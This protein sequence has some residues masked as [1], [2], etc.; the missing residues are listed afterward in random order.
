MERNEIKNEISKLKLDCSSLVEKN[1]IV[2]LYTQKIIEKL[3][4]ITTENNEEVAVKSFHELLSA[5]W[6]LI[7]GS[8]LSYTA[9]PKH[10]LT[11]FLCYLSKYLAVYYNDSEWPAIRFLMPTVCYESY[12]AKY[13]DLNEVDLHKV[14]ET[15]V[16]SHYRGPSSQDF[17]IPIALLTHHELIDFK[18]IK[19]I[20]NPYFDHQKHLESQASFSESELSR[21]Y[22]HSEL[23]KNIGDTIDEYFSS[24]FPSLLNK[25]QKLHTTLKDNS[26]IGSGKE[27]KA[28]ELAYAEIVEFMTFWDKLEENFIQSIPTIK[29]EIELIKDLASDKTKNNDILSCFDIRQRKLQE[30]IRGNEEKLIKITINEEID[31]KNHKK[32]EELILR[33]KQKITVLNRQL[34]EDTY[35]GCDAL[36]AITQNI[37]KEM[38][39]VPGLKDI[40][41]LINY[42]SKLSNEK[43]N[44]FCTIN[45]VEI[46][47]VIKV[48]DLHFLAKLP[49]ESFGPLLNTVDITKLI[50]T[51]EHLKSCLEWFSLTQREI[52]CEALGEGLSS[53]IKT[54]SGYEGVSQY[55]P[56]KQRAVIEC[57]FLLESF[58]TYYSSQELKTYDLSINI[59]LK[60]ELINVVHKLENNPTELEPIFKKLTADQLDFIFTDIKETLLSILRKGYALKSIFRYLNTWLSSALVDTLKEE[61]PVII[62]NCNCLKETLLFLDS[63]QQMMLLQSI[64][65]CWLLIIKSSADFKGVFECLKGTKSRA[66]VFDACIDIILSKIKNI[67]DFIEVFKNLNSEQRTTLLQNFIKEENWSLI[68]KNSGDFNSV[69][70]C[71]KEANSRAIM[72]DAYKEKLQYII[73]SGADLKNIF[74]YLTNE[75]REFIFNLVKE[76]LASKIENIFHFS[77]AFMYLT[78]EQCMMLLQN[79]GKECWKLIIKNSAAFKKALACF[80]EEN[81]RAVVFNTCI[82]IIPSKIENIFRF[83]D[84][85]MYLTSEQRMMLLQSFDKE[86]WKLVIKSSADFKKALACFTEDNQRAVIFDACIDIIPLKIENIFHFSD[87]FI[88]LTSEQRMMLLQNFDKE[89]WKLIIKSSADFKKVLE[90]LTKSNLCSIM[91]D[92][93]KEQLLSII[94]TADFK[95]FIDYLPVEEFSFVCKVLKEEQSQDTQVSYLAV[96]FNDLAEDRLQEVCKFF[97]NKLFSILSNINVSLINIFKDLTDARLRIIC[98]IFKDLHSILPIFDYLTKNQLN[99]VLGIFKE[100]FLSILKDDSNLISILMDQNSKTCS[101]VCEFFYDECRKLIKNSYNLLVCL[102]A[103]KYRIVYQTL[104]L[105]NLPNFNVEEGFM[106]NSQESVLN[107]HSSLADIEFDVSKA[108]LMH[109]L[110]PDHIAINANEDDDEYEGDE[111]ERDEYESDKYENDDEEDVQK[112]NNIDKENL[113]LLSKLGDPE[114]KDIVENNRIVLTNGENKKFKIEDLFCLFILPV[115]ELKKAFCVDGYSS[116][117]EILSYLSQRNLEACLHE[118]NLK[119]AFHSDKNQIKYFFSVLATYFDLKSPDNFLK[120]IIKYHNNLKSREEQTKSESFSFFNRPG[121]SKTKIDQ[122]EVEMFEKKTN[123]HFFYLR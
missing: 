40:H 120:K 75:Q 80:T 103:D 112:L 46:L 18:E 13:P 26:V 38:C 77:N 79:F 25:L 48:E 114:L 105:E 89:R 60:K 85:F 43:I 66:I 76:T 8:L 97:N 104:K 83:S 33:F 11:K 34:K 96:L 24:I 102:N 6:N 27:D 86:R 110:F 78:S 20:Y 82:D 108:P 117:K 14:L 64:K 73:H 54:R 15:H 84:A 121:P 95:I 74:E 116:Q 10:P 47:G 53:I 3:E 68:I 56:S 28:G 88:Y 107:S 69:F 51:N 30:V 118:L 29:Q 90:C 93:S 59:A 36:E 91:L 21:L 39:I 61:W 115:N 109:A 67:S 72:F 98:E 81:Q 63:A 71:L 19:D 106:Q 35:F 92:S 94:Y 49:G 2:L 12:D 113:Y 87:A 42:L 101:I 122:D 52:V 70:E 123:A 55:L 111:Y 9:L 58:Q 31:L 16:M 62:K 50:K 44:L 4:E 41:E 37:S 119:D 57:K 17:L 1:K 7:N 23:T 22:K 65:D 32:V 100:E 45:S 5:N 99:I